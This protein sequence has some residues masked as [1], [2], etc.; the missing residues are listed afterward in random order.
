MKQILVIGAGLGGLSVAIRLARQGRRVTVLEK[1]ERIGGKMNVWVDKGYTF[2]TGPTLLTMP[3]V[4]EDLFA[5]VGKRLED[6]LELVRVDP[7]CRYFFP[8]GVRLEAFSD[9]GR[10]EEEIRR[11]SP[12][13]V[14]HFRRFMEHAEGIYRAAAGPFLF[15]GLTSL[16]PR[17]ILKN[18]KNLA[19]VFRIDPFRTLNSAVTSY[20]DDPHLRQLFNRFATYNGSSPFLAPATLAI[21]P[22]VEM[23]MGGWYVRGGMFRL[24]Q[25]LGNIALEEGVEI[26]TGVEVIGIVEKGGAAAGVLTAGQGFLPADGV[27]SNADALYAREHLLVKGQ[28]AVRRYGRDHSLSGF[29]MLLG[30]RKTYPVLSHHN[31]FFSADYRAEFEALFNDQRPAGDPTVYAA[32]SSVHDPGHAPTG[33]TNLFVLVNAPALSPRVNWDDEKGLYRETVLR[34]LERFGV[35]V[36]GRDI[37][38][39]NFITPLDF[40]RRYHAQRGAIYGSSSN[41]RM[42]A[43]RRPPNRAREMKN[44]YFVGGSSHPGGGIPLVLLSGKIVADLVQEQW[45]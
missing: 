33:C 40:E 16:G 45:G 42:A 24:A 6:H 32:V 44:L 7:I 30:V 38:T 26:R 36:T 20:F 11:I 19:S 22:Y 5:S 12:P 28:E 4:V 39:E 41:S 18:L 29:V 1:N 21:I 31:I 25:A 15:T 23:R 35:E 10:M 27:V 8:D 3:F 17:G 2:D 14:V 13:D 37:V 43:F 34:K 9:N